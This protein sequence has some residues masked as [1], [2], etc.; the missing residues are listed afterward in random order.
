MG[1]LDSVTQLGLAWKPSQLKFA[2]LKTRWD[3]NKGALMAVEYR[4]EHANFAIEATVAKDW[5]SAGGTN[6]TLATPYGRRDYSTPKFGLS[7]SLGQ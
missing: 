4:P 2:Q 3:I 6:A 7:F 1:S 5:G